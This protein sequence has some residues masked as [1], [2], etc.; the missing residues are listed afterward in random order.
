LDNA[1]FT[2]T[3]KWEEAFAAGLLKPAE[4]EDLTQFRMARNRLVHS[5]SVDAESIAYWAKRSERLLQALEER[6]T[7]IGG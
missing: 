4:V 7:K 2:S 1:G 3:Y 5:D 6:L